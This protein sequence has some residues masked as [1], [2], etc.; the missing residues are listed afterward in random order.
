MWRRY[1]ASKVAL[2]FSVLRSARHASTKPHD[3]VKLS[4][5]TS[6][7]AGLAPWFCKV[8]FLFAGGRPARHTLTVAPDALESLKKR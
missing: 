8:S 2:S 5:P 3:A 7:A 1:A 6:T 4:A